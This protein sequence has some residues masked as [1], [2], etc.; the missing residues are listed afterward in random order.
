MLPSLFIQWNAQGDT[1]HLIS[2]EKPETREIPGSG[3][4]GEG[5]AFVVLLYHV[6]HS[7][8]ALQISKNIPSK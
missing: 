6:H 7:G 5:L 3:E 8:G 4:F 1:K 2:P